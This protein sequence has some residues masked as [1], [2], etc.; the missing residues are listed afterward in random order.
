MYLKIRVV[1][2]AKKEKVEKVSDDTYHVWVQVPAENNAANA[3]VLELLRVE[4]P[5]LPSRIVSG[6]HSPSKIVS[7]G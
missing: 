2:D 6:H 4:Y 7:I 3:R 1:P 5:N